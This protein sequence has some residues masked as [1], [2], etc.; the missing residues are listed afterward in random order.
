MARAG[1]HRHVTAENV[2]APV[3]DA[4]ARARAI[5]GATHAEVK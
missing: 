5:H 1:F 4:L 2:C 3:E